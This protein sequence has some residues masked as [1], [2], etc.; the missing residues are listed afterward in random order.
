MSA[1]DHAE[2]IPPALDQELNRLP[3][4]YRVPLVLC[5]LKGLT[6]HQAA[7]ELRCPVGTIRSR[8][9]RGRE[10]LKQRLTRR[11]YSPATAMLGIGPGFSIRSFTASVPQPLAQATVAAAGRYLWGASSGLGTVALAFSSRSASTICGPVSALAQGVITTMALAQLKFVAA[12]LTAAGLL[13][14]GL[15]M[16]AWALGSPGMGQQG[17][18]P[19]PA[20]KFT[21][22]A[23]TTHSDI[24]YLGTGE[25]ATAI[26]SSGVEARLADLERK[27][28][29]LLQR[30][31]P[32]QLAGDT[33]PA[34]PPAVA[35]GR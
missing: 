4:R 32:P 21:P 33:L 30:L 12:S 6:H 23:V 26:P 25:V 3:S 31:S 28:D 20:K 17:D 8:L 15:G 10:L 11:G 29:L 24:D 27:L 7:D 35:I 16:G 22:K 9:A 5:Y 13:A 18:T 34:T 14:G 19:A 1:Y 2:E